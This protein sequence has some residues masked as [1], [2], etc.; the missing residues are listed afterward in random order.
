MQLRCW[1]RQPCVGIKQLGWVCEG[2]LETVMGG[3]ISPERDGDGRHLPLTPMSRTVN[4]ARVEQESQQ[5]SLV[6]DT[7]R[8]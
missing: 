8:K 6:V 2:E 3:S 5:T 7:V 4:L 1:T